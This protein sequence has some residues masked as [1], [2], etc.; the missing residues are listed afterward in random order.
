MLLRSDDDRVT[1]EITDD[2]A[3]FDA[4]AG[5]APTG[6]GSADQ[7]L[8][9]SGGGYGL[10]GIRARVEQV[11]GTVLVRSAPGAGTTIRVEVPYG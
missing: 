11:H 6:T 8:A 4:T 7:G 1:L 3:G 2:G 10:A 5:P 9:G